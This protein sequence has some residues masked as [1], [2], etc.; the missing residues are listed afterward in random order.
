V[1]GLDDV[2]ALAQLSHRRL[3]PLRER[4]H[5]RLPFPGKPIALKRLEAADAKRP[6]EV[7]ADLAGFGT[8]VEWASS[9]FLDHR[10]VDAGE[11]LGPYLGLQLLAQL[12]IRF[13]TELQR[14][15]LL[16][17]QA[18]AIGDVVLGDVCRGHPCRG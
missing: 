11:T 1:H 2:A 14:R 5:H 8:E 17:P 10:P 16:R 18:H 4:P 3:Q 6:V 7:G 9:R 13:R 15:P 12:Q